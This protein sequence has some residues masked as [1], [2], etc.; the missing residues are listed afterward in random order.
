VAPDK[1]GD[2]AYVG[3]GSVI[4]RDVPAD[5][6]AVARGRQEMKEGWA[7]RLR[8]AREERKAPRKGK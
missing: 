8:E 5:A 4:G 1:I 7:R 6:L 2:G 3:S